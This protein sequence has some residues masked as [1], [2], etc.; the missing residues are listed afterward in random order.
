VWD[1]ERC[2]EDLGAEPSVEGTTY[3]THAC[4]VPG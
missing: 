1:E 2:I 4:M 3:K